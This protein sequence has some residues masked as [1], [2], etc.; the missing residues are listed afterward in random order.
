MTGQKDHR[1]VQLED[2]W[3]VGGRV[4]PK[5]LPFSRFEVAALRPRN[6][7]RVSSVKPT[8]GKKVRL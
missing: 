4:L 7:Y 8:S 6:N 5:V 1:E 3:R 2:S